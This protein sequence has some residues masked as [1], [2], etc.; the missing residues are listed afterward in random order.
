MR[1]PR[2]CNE[3]HIRQSTFE[4]KQKLAL[5]LIYQLYCADAFKNYLEPKFWP[6][7]DIGGEDLGYGVGGSIH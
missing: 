5:A 2:I 4:I 6:Q 7:N 1:L 3:R